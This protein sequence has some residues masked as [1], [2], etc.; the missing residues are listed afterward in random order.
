MKKYREVIIVTGGAG[1]I[2]SN[3]LN[4]FVPKRKNTLFINVDCLTSAGSLDNVNVS[5]CS[6]YKFVKVDIAGDNKVQ[7]VFKKYQ[8]T[9]VINF[10][11][12]SHVDVSIKNPDIFIKT[13]I[14]GTHNL[15]KSSLK[16]GVRRFLQVSTD[17]VYGA[18]DKKSKPFTESSVIEPNNPYSASKVGAEMLARSY[19]RTFGLPVVITR[20]SNTYGPNQDTSKLLPKFISNLLHDKPVP[21]YGKGAQI[22]EWLYVDDHALGIDLAFRRGVPGEIYNIGGNTELTN[23]ELT[24]KLLNLLNK[25]SSLI[26]FVPDR[27]GHDFRYS[28][29]SKKA[30][31]KLGWKPKTT[32]D[33]GIK[34]TIESSKK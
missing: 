13:N 4:L 15:L 19:Y 24:K 5:N 26:N 11:A 14:I 33:S 17:E 30:H 2:G 6:N 18:L 22:R 7:T 21:L 10:A 34:K 31:K 25:P 9:G 1:F 20:G 27:L 8:P 32:F 3:Y 23:L 12:E 28:L 29:S 16:Y